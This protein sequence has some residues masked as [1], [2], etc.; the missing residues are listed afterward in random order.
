MDE[1]PDAISLF[2]F[3]VQSVMCV[4]LIAR[5]RVIGALYLESRKEGIFVKKD[6]EPLEFFASQA[7]V[8][9]ENA[10]LN[11]ELEQVSRDRAEE[12]RDFS[13]KFQAQVIQKGI[14]D[15]EGLERTLEVERARIITNFIQDASHHFRTPLSI[16]NTSVDIVTRKM[17]SNVYD[18]YFDS[19]RSQVNVIVELVDTLNYMVKLDSAVFPLNDDVKLNDVV[20]D[21]YHVKLPIAKEKGITYKIEIANTNPVIKG[22]TEYL[23]QAVGR[24]IDNAI[25]F[26]PTGHLVTVRVWEDNKYCGIEVDDMG[27][28]ISKEDFPNIFKRFFRSDKAGTTRGLGVGLSIAQRIVELHNGKIEVLTEENKGSIFRMKFAKGN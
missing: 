13:E 22:S 8:S 7:A 5:N 16:I 1:M 24:L 11:A 12:L 18:H 4:P 6:I 10:M 14:I 27:V 3:E 26:T 17:D 25:T 2:E 28:G 9:I 23:R 15:K 21:M 20:Q 19:I